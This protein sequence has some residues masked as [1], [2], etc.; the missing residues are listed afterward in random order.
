MRS[1]GPYG[2]SGQ[3]A[4]RELN[5]KYERLRAAIGDLGSCE[6]WEPRRAAFDVVS[7]VG[8]DGKR[9][10]LQESGPGAHGHPGDV[11]RPLPPER[12]HVVDGP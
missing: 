2:T 1:G 12:G 7:F 11:E 5:T 6:D 8:R 9:A 10:E 3:A 4:S